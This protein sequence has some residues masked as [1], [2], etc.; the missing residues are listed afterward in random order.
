MNA[1]RGSSRKTEMIPTPNITAADVLAARRELAKRSFPDFTGMVDIPTVPVSDLDEEDRFNTM[2]HAGLAAHHQL[3]CHEF[4]ELV[5][6]RIPNLMLLLPPGSAKALAL[7]TPIPTPSGWKP[8]G[9]LVV[10]DQVF[11]EM[12][13][14]CRVTWVSPV[15]RNRPVYTVR[16]DC[17][18]EI[19]ADEDH[20]WR[21]QLCRKHPVFKIK[22]TKLLARR[23]AKRPMIQRAGAL[24]LPEA[25]LPADPYLLGVWLGD[26]NSAGMRVSS[27]V[28]DQVWLRAELERAEI[29]TSNSSSSTLFGVLG[30]RKAFASLGLIHD[31]AHSTH[32]RK[33]IP[34]MYLRASRAQ[35]LALLQGLIDT[36]GTICGKRGC[37][38][39]CNT[40]LELA[41]QVRELVRSLGVKAGW[42]EGR[43]KLNGV[44]HGPAYR[45]SFYHAQ[46]ARMPRKAA[47]CRDQWRTPN[48]YVEAE[49][50]GRADTVCIEVD[51]PSHLFLCGR[52]MTPTHNSTYVDVLGIP[53]Y[54]ATHPR[55]NVILGSY[56]T[57][58]ARKQGRRAR[59]LVKSRSFTNL[60]PGV[61]LSTD[62]SAAHEWRLSTGGEFMAAGLT[63]GITGNRASL[64]ILDDPVKGREQAESEGFRQKTWDAYVDDFCSRLIPGAPQVMILTRWHGDDVAGRILPEDWKGES[65]MF[66]GR[67]GRMWK[68]ICLPA[69]AEHLTDPLGRKIGETLWPE[70]FNHEHWAPFK[71]NA[72][73]WSSL[74]QQRPAPEEGTFFQRA[75]FNRYDLKDRPKFLHVYMTSDHATKQDGGDYTV[76]RIWGV[77]H[78]GDLYLLGGFR[79]QATADVWSEE[80]IKLIKTWKPLCWFPENDNA[81]KVVAPFVQ[82]M[83]YAEK[84]ACRREPLTTAGGDKALKAQAFQGMAN[85]GRVW[86]PSTPWAD[87]VLD[88]YLRFPTGKHDDEIDA[89]AHMGR[90]LDMAHP[91]ILKF[92]V[93]PEGPQDRYAKARPSSGTSE[94]DWVVS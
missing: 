9:D 91:A 11:D 24:E 44:D 41:Q 66:A 12:G 2:R 63:S 38:T 78:K 29:K 16:T 52:S 88:E 67:D 84:V 40:N 10:G 60:F 87:E 5:E 30:Q 50:A 43:S 8:M 6:G 4:Q 26:G 64:G 37:A 28:E 59:Q 70:W 13:E 20:E 69:I 36:D 17:G 54:M 74:Y 72:R 7:D 85:S 51:S 71:K 49:E 68:V 80:A 21:V 92:P 15:W 34:P 90:A 82:R 79:M 46:A 58:I 93:R 32:G 14:P 23:R 33:H 61:T 22:E 53:W 35:R 86:L 76:F 42:S 1:S 55:Q 48:T 77:D 56:A 81:W 75:W 57:P 94:N 27:S 25:A 31:P 65:G 19:V 89:A 62:S 3:I 47:L 18:D 39:F 73:T 83:L 45:V